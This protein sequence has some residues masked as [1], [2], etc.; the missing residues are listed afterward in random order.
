VSPPPVLRDIHRERGAT[1]LVLILAFVVPG[2]ILGMIAW[3]VL[4]GPHVR[5]DVVLL[6]ML[7][8][9]Y[10][11]LD[12]AP[13][14]YVLRHIARGAPDVR[15]DARGIVW[16]DDRRRHLSLDWDEVA[17]VRIWPNPIRLG[18]T[19]VL[20]FDPVAGHHVTHR[21]GLVERLRNRLFR[22]EYDS[23]FVVRTW[24]TD[25]SFTELCDLVEA[26]VPQNTLP[27]GGAS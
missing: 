24:A 17:G 2:L 14:A 12:L 5:D 26:R 1:V 23:R 18:D 11:A 8:L 10:V 27:S 15:L 19:G 4:S 20:V 3:N 16:G 25:C 9:I 22:F 13:S 6:I 7:G 21:A